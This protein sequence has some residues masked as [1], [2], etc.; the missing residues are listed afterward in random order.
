[1]SDHMTIPEAI[2]MVREYQSWRRGAISPQLN[3]TDIG[4]AIDMIITALALA[5]PPP[6]SLSAIA[7]QLQTIEPMHP[8]PS[9]FWRKDE[10]REAIVF[11]RDR[12]GEEVLR[13]I[14]NSSRIDHLARLLAKEQHTA[15]AGDAS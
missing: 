13:I 5:T 2:A 10:K 15:N 6:P 14:G 8:E 9:C 4:R 12:P 11:H 7:G 3:P 1:M